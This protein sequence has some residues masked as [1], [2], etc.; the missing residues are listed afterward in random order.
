MRAITIAAFSLFASVALAE[1]PT[2]NADVAK[3]RCE[4]DWASDF[5]MV[6]FCLDQDRS[7]FA[8]FITRSEALNDR[9]NLFH[10]PFVKCQSDWQPDWMMVEFCAGQQVKSWREL[11]DTIQSL[12]DDIGRRIQFGCAADWDPDI[13]MMAFCASQ[14]A[15]SWRALYN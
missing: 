14:Q 9:S 8:E 7:A 15:E 12:P 4:R 2:Y 1:I 11:Q 3:A 10:E 13:Q 5:T 6:K